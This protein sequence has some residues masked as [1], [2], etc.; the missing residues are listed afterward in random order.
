MVYFPD[1]VW[2]IIKSYQINFN[3]QIKTIQYSYLTRF[4]FNNDETDD[5]YVSEDED[6]SKYYTFKTLYY[7]TPSWVFEVS[8]VLFF[9]DIYDMDDDDMMINWEQYLLLNTGGVLYYDFYYLNNMKQEKIIDIENHIHQFQPKIQSKTKLNDLTKIIPEEYIKPI[10]DCITRQLLS[11]YNKPN[12][13]TINTNWLYYNTINGYIEEFDNQFYDN[14]DCLNPYKDYDEEY[15]DDFMENYK[16]YDVRKDCFEY[17]D[18][19]PINTTILS[20]YLD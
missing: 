20:E 9:D 16:A 11:K 17:T 2:S 14:D 12:K 3:P 19:N 10:K 15:A 6:D 5:E 8:R 7:I 13:N 18:F 1:D 4:Q